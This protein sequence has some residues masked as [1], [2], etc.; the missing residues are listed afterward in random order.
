MFDDDDFGFAFLLPWPVGLILLIVF[1][2]C[3]VWYCNLPDDQKERMCAE[4]A[5][6]YHLESRYDREFDCLVRIDDT[7]WQ[8]IEKY[9]KTGVIELKDGVKP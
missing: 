5:A 8:K 3:S 6:E 7:H 2:C 4:K 1:I 9:K